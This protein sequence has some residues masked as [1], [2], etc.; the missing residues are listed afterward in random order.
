MVA[1]MLASVV[2][3][4]RR[5]R[6]RTDVLCHLPRRGVGIPRSFSAAAMPP[7]LTMPCCS[8]ASTDALLFQCLD[9]RPQVLGVLIGLRFDGLYA[10]LVASTPLHER[11]QK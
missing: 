11:E 5:R 1:R 6:L 10:G 7:R 8:S 4:R 2:Q 9:H 3:A